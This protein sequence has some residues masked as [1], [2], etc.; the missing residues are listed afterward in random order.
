MVADGRR[1]TIESVRTPGA[2]ISHASY[3]ELT[4]LDGAIILD[5]GIVD[6]QELAAQL[7][8]PIDTDVVVKAHVS[9][10]FGMSPKSLRQ[11]QSRVNELAAR[12]N[13]N[14]T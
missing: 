1:I 13:D 7:R 14:P 5:I 6:D 2:P 3:F 10:R 8:N 9:H 11:L 12:L 4:E